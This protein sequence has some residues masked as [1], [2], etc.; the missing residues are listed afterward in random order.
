MLLNLGTGGVA[1]RVRARLGQGGAAPGGAALLGADLQRP[2]GR[3][4][5]AV[6]RGRAGPAQGAMRALSFIRLCI[7]NNMAAARQPSRQC[8]AL[9]APRR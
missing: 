2:A 8:L 4:H 5:G 7:R 1:L 9:S 6:L 3:S